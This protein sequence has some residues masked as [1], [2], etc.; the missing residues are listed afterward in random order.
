MIMAAAGFQADARK[1]Q[2][3]TANYGKYI[4]VVEGAIPTGYGGGFS[5]TGAAGTPFIDEVRHVSRAPR[6]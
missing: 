1:Q 6:S 3:M 2:A 5:T 4:L